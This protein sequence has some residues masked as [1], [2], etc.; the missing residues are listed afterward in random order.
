MRRL[1]LLTALLV[2]CDGGSVNGGTDSGNAMD[3]DMGVVGSTGRTRATPSQITQAWIGLEMVR[4]NLCDEP[5]DDDEGPRWLPD[6]AID[7]V[8]G[9]SLGLERLPTGDYC[10]IEVK[11]GR[12][13]DNGSPLGDE[14]ALIL[15]GTTTRGTPFVIHLPDEIEFRVD[16]SSA[17]AISARAETIGAVLEF[18]LSRWIAEVDLDGLPLTDG[19]AIIDEHR[20]GDLLEE[21]EEA[22]SRSASVFVDDDGDLEPDG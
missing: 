12:R 15:E 6:A 9:V 10:S 21:I 19:V 16:D 22:V 20:N 1:L 11:I 7:L 4:P 2:G 8:G 3:V 17:T 5:A 14:L 13:E 18:D